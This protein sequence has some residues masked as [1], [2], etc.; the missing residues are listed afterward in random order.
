M[1]KQIA[2]VRGCFFYLFLI[3]TD[4][5]VSRILRVMILKTSTYLHHQ[6]LI[7]KAMFLIKMIHACCVT[8]PACLLNNRAEYAVKMPKIKYS[9]R[10]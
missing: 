3:I 6:F 8:L 1:N 10:N 7:M 9:H 2:R 4:E 5:R